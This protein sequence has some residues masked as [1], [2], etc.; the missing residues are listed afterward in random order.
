M[1]NDTDKES[2]KTDDRGCFMQVRK[3]RASKGRMP[4]NVR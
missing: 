4:D 1:M 3:V 2:S